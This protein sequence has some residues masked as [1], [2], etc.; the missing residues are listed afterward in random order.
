MY[1]QCLVKVASEYQY[2]ED[3]NNLVLGCGNS[4]AI[5]TGVTTVL[6]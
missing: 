2:E 5:C 1:I 4:S 6:H 3:V